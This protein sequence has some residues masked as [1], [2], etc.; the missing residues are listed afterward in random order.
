MKRWTRSVNPPLA[1]ALLSA[2]VLAACG[3]GRGTDAGSPDAQGAQGS[4]AS[5]SAAVIIDGRK[6]ALANAPGATN[7]TTTQRDAVRLADQA[8]FGAT[9][10][11]ITA[12]RG[13]GVEPW[14]AAQFAATGSTY[15]SGGG[16]DIH[17]NDNGDF[18]ATR[19][20]NCWRDWYSTDPLVWDFYRNA[21][22]Q[23]D[24]LRQRV[25]FAL[26]QIVVVS[27]V[28]V[29]GTYGFR[30]YHNML[31]ANAFGNYREVLRRV[32]LSPVMGE[33]LDHV[34]NNKRYPNENFARELLQLFAIGTCRLNADGTLETGRCV[35]TYDNDVVRNYAFALTGW[36]YP[37]GGSTVWGCWPT[38]ANCAYFGGDMVGVASRTDNLARSLLSGVNVPAT[39]TATQALNLV[40]DSL[41]NQPSMAPFIAKQLIQHLVKS[42]P[43]PGYVQRVSAAFNTGRYQGLTR[44]FG[45]GTKGDL[46][47]TVA[48]VLLDA[49]AR[50]SAAP[51]VAEKLREPVLMVTGVL[52]AL[53]GASDGAALGWWWGETLR[54]HIF[55]SPSVFNFYSPSYPV[56]GTPLVG[57]AFG[58]Y[59]VNT[60]FSRLNYLNQLL[61]WGG[62][63]ADTSIPG[64]TGTQVNLSAFEAD[65]AD[66][67]LLVNRLANLATGGRMTSSAKS[68]IV[69][70]VNAWTSA[71]S[72][73]WRTE[74]VRTAAYLV[75][76]SPAYQVLN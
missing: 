36:T 70:A 68:N 65:A 74:R 37:A 67:T 58:I 9:E 46:T 52:R 71:Q 7:T 30:N 59:N 50:T 23:G 22:T 17:V 73:S 56:A 26:A 55:R 25:A 8:S 76:A 64:A 24:Q 19:G 39:R 32:T 15:A 48:A 29:S 69:T 41:M 53:N 57:P 66:A 20:N 18:C 10:A 44:S 33:Y 35:P 43:T 12:I 75:F 3:G 6:T 11:L 14:L 45:G 54:Q 13:Q 4:G 60:A 5:S 47:A 21:M 1:A 34:N 2:L 27:G 38:G 61:H 42:N 31:L 62:M 28:E 72:S 51:L 16:H 49:E 63:S 40:L